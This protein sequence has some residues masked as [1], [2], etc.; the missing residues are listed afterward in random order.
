MSTY[1]VD[2]MANTHTNKLRKQAD[3]EAKGFEAMTVDRCARSKQPVQG[4]DKLSNG[5]VCWVKD[6]TTGRQIQIQ[7]R[8]Q[9]DWN[10]K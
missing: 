4:A 2:L 7:L 6:S 9:K 5:S 1:Y 8:R 10:I 3:K